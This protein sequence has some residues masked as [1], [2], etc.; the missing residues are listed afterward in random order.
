M[1]SS[2]VPDSTQ[3]DPDGHKIVFENEHTRVLEVRSHTGQPI[4][5]HSHPP[6]L[7]VAVNGYRLRST[8]QDGEES[9]IDRR[10]G[11]IKWVE[12]ET[13]EAQVLIGP[14]HVIEVEVKSAL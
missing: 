6:R 1:N 7:V 4:P 13:H 8:T 3:V 14:T 2:D 9:I 12:H 5:M 11:E 10:P